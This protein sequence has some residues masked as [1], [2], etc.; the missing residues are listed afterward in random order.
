M[1]NEP[2]PKTQYYHDQKDRTFVREVS[3]EYNL[4]K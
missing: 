2:A 4:T 1:D 3:G